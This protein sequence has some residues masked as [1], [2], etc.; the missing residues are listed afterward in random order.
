MTGP[1]GSRA[2]EHKSVPALVLSE[3]VSQVEVAALRATMNLARRPN[4]LYE[5]AALEELF[6]DLRADGLSEAEISGFIAQTLGI[7]ASVVR[8]R[9]KLLFS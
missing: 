9:L 7:S 2:L 5:A 1:V 3:D 6:D 4:Q 8:Q